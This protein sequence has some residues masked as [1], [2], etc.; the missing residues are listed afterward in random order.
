M[1]NRLL[2]FKNRLL[3]N[4]NNALLRDYPQYWLDALEE[5][6][7]LIKNSYDGKNVNSHSTIEVRCPNCGNIRSVHI[8]DLYNG[9]GVNLCKNCSITYASSF[10]ST[11]DK[12]LNSKKGWASISLED[13]IKFAINAQKYIS[14]D[15]RR[16]NLLKAN[17]VHYNN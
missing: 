4:I 12:I 10:I 17:K 11:E 7:I 16:N 13:H 9:H 5:A 14:A 6:R 2:Y 3:L 8:K 1:D 15:S